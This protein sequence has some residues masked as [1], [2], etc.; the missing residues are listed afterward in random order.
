MRRGSVVSASPGPGRAGGH[1]WIGDVETVGILVIGGGQAGLAVG[2]HLRRRGLTAGRD[3]RIIDDSPEPGGAWRRMWPGM[4]LISP[5]PYSSLPGTV[6]PVGPGGEALDPAQVTRY[7]SDYEERFGLDVHRGVRATRVTC[8]DTVRVETTAGTVEADR[9]VNATGTWARPFVP[10]WPGQG[11]FRGRQLHTVHYR[12]PEEF[13]GLRV[14]VVGG[15][16]SAAQIMTEIAPVAADTRWVTR[17]PPRFL[18]D[19][20][21]GEALFELASARRRI[22]RVD[23]EA[24]ASVADLVD[25]VMVPEVREARR[26]R[27]LVAHRPFTRF[28]GDDLVW[29]DQ[30][31]RWRA[32]A[33]V[34]ATGF[35][36]AL[37]H[38]RGTGL[39]LP[40]GRA[41]V[42][43]TATARCDPRVDFVGYGD[44][45][46][47]ASGTLV[48][49]GQ[50]A[51]RTVSRLLGP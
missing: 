2:W 30:G 44:W 16:N 43:D 12:G 39:L 3:F 22:A 20:I 33:V 19:D 36:P 26:R 48:G 50:H 15:G 47:V 38:L 21:D 24:E 10:T 41:D 17:R 14:A 25:I 9:I 8:G 40:N 6:M 34:W 51:G 46:G 4:R 31:V 29:R 13:A 45:T 35:R 37:R 5:A 32:D 7:L 27:D 23:D 28:D 11:G 18:P 1:D 42:V 49:V